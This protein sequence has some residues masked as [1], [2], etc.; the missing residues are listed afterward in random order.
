MN[1]RD[2]MFTKFDKG[3]SSLS[4]NPT[5]TSRNWKSSELGHFSVNQ[6]F[7]NAIANNLRAEISSIFELA[8]SFKIAVYSKFTDI[9]KSYGV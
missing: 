1:I 8:I 9:S 2:S 7:H 6:H 4:P 3:I 5:L